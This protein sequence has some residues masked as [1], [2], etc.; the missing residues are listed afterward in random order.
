MENA[1]TA[2]VGQRR[3]I[4]VSRAQKVWLERAAQALDE[5]GVSH[6]HREAAK[7]LREVTDEWR[8]AQ[9]LPEDEEDTA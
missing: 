9:V 3:T 6:A 8:A 1:H 5:L 4:P 2:S 7:V